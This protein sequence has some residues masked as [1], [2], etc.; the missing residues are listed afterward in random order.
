LAQPEGRVKEVIYP[1]VGEHILQDLVTE[2]QASGRSYN[3][4][5]HRVMRGMYSHHYR[6][7]VPRLLSALVFATT[8]AGSVAIFHLGRFRV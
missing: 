6:R 1:V 5:A 3:E 2:S 7:M 8:N 4:R